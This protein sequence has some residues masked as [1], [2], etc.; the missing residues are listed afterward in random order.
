MS[1]DDER[2]TAIEERAA[3]ATPGPWERDTRRKTQYRVYCDDEVGSGI[4]DCE[5]SYALMLCGDD[6][7]A[8]AEFIAH[9]RED[10]P[11]LLG[12]VADLRSRLSRMEREGPQRRESAGER[13]PIDLRAED[14][15]EAQAAIRDRADIIDMMRSM[16]C[17]EMAGR[18]REFAD[19]LPRLAA[20]PS[21]SVDTESGANG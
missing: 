13:S 1:M 11:Y 15:T 5:S 19:A 21:P 18:L 17:T 4:A 12:V 8:N 16:D 3:K 9:A 14:V 2:L 7:I 6:F 10:V 20:V